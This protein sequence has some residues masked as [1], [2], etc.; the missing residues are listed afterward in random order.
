MTT[1]PPMLGG[2]TPES[3]MQ[4]VTHR[5][6]AQIQLEARSQGRKLSKRERDTLEAGAM[7]GAAHMF[8]LFEEIAREQAR[9]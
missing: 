8:L 4:E 5:A 9:A 1:P 3:L 7:V 2:Y 6:L